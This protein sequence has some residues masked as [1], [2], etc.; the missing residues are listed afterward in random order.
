MGSPRCDRTW[1]DLQARILERV[2]VYP[3]RRV[4]SL[5][6][7]TERIQVSRGQMV[8]NVSRLY[9]FEDAIVH[10]AIYNRMA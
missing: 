9:V 10:K 7:S 5:Y 2:H 3:D 8:M 4:L 6:V 1:G